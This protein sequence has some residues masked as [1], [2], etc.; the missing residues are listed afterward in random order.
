MRHLS[1]AIVLDEAVVD[2]HAEA[3]G[4]VHGGQEH[5]FNLRDGTRRQSATECY[6]RRMN[7]VAVRDLRNDTASVV[8]LIEQGE[9]VTLTNRGRP[10]ARIVPLPVEKKKW[11]TPDEVV[12]LPQADPSLRAYLASLRESETDWDDPLR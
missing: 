11:L 9:E 6:D 4:D 5:P 7:A 1:P 2:G 8:R 12:A 10:I 3:D